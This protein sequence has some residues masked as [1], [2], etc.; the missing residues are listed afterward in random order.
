MLKRRRRRNADPAPSLH[1]GAQTTKKRK[2]GGRVRSTYAF[3]GPDASGRTLDED[4]EDESEKRKGSGFRKQASRYAS[5]RCS[6][7]MALNIDKFISRTAREQ[8]AAA[9]ERRFQHVVGSGRQRDSVKER[10]TPDQDLAQDD[11]KN[12]ESNLDEF[13]IVPETD[14]ERRQR[15]ETE[16]QSGQQES[17]LDSA[18]LADAPFATSKASTSSHRSTTLASESTVPLRPT[19][20]VYREIEARKQEALGLNEQR[21]LEK[22]HFSHHSPLAVAPVQDSDRKHTDNESG[23]HCWTCPACTLCVSV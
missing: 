20:S 2:V 7:L 17:L 15:L 9:A 6:L 19:F 22:S 12:T 18:S 16:N 1:T 5:V 4:V 21:T 13:D 23:T 8:R 14:A 11:D 10:E 3:G